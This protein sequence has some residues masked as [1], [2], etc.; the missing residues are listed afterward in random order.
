M[1][2]PY[3]NNI[4][5]GLF[6]PG[7]ENNGGDSKQQGAE[8]EQEGSEDEEEDDESEAS[9]PSGTRVQGLVFFI[10]G[11]NH[12]SFVIDLCRLTIA[13]ELLS[14]QPTNHMT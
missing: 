4:S 5:P 8:G 13:I 10:P 7:D 14:N 12:T 3:H 1:T 9:T 6:S 11:T 2:I